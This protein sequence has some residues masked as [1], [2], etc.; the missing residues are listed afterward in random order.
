MEQDFGTHKFH[1]LSLIIILMFG[2]GGFLF[3]SYDRQLQIIIALAVSASYVVWGTVHHYAEKN[4]NWKIMVE[5]T[6][7]SII[8]LAIMIS[9]VLRT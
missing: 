6:L 8:S 3:F 1:Y 4:L 5:Y 2:Y 9:L 7:F